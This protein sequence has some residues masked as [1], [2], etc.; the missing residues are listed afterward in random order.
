MMAAAAALLLAACGPSDVV[1]K[2]KL[3]PVNEGMKLADLP[4][5]LG[6]GPLAPNQPAD[7][8]RLFNGYRT[9]VFLV[10]GKQYRV[11]WYR[12]K[13]GSIEEEIS[14]ERETPVLLENDV[15]IGKGWAFFDQTAEEVGIPNP[16]RTRERLDSIAQAQTR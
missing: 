10:Q 4:P 6:T 13:P 9:Q 16:Y 7:S 5:V 11:V 12:D 1:G 14:R 2:E 3:G 8:L 15:V